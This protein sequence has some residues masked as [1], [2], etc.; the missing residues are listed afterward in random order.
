MSILPSTATLWSFFIVLAVLL[1]CTIITGL[2]FKSLKTNLRSTIQSN[3]QATV[4]ATLW[5]RTWR[6]IRSIMSILFH[7]LLEPVLSIAYVQQYAD[8]IKPS[9]DLPFK[10]SKV[11]KVPTEVPHMTN[12]WLLFV[13]CL[14]YVVCRVW[15]RQL[16]HH[17]L[18]PELLFLR[19]QYRMIPYLG[20]SIGEKSIYWH[21]LALAR[22]VLRFFMLPVWFGLIILIVCFLVLQDGVLALIKVL[23]YISLKY[24]AR[25]GN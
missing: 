23:G 18:V 4:D 24:L 22:D 19:D 21:P 16:V 7:R 14:L 5:T 1:L 3:V 13:I 20:D 17:A 11:F 12:K 6:I 8:M 25:E 10:W 2:S 15:L 9:Q